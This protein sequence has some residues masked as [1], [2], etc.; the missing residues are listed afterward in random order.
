M[1]KWDMGFI[2]EM[3]WP[4]MGYTIHL[5]CSGL[6]KTCYMCKSPLHSKFLVV[7]SLWAPAKRILSLDGSMDIT[8]WAPGIDFPN[9][10]HK[11]IVINTVRGV[12][13]FFFFFWE[14]NAKKLS[15]NGIKTQN[16]YII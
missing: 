15:L 6:Q 16:G 3:P 11:L 7:G 8:S 14:R 12:V 4:T 1:K 9:F 10:I 13:S 5:S 2:Q